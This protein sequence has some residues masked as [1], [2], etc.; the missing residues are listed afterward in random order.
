MLCSRIY[1]ASIGCIFIVHDFCAL[2]LQVRTFCCERV[3]WLELPM[4]APVVS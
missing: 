2:C 3:I 4:M 1:S